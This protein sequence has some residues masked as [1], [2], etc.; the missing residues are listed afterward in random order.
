MG[1][2]QASAGLAGTSCA[3]ADWLAEFDFGNADVVR[4]DVDVRIL[5]RRLFQRDSKHPQGAEA[6]GEGLAQFCDRFLS[7]VCHDFSAETD[8]SL[9]GIP[10]TEMVSFHVL[11]SWA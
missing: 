5:D 6:T 11:S 10:T 8:G 9:G 3:L 2:D 4:I 7:R 1:L